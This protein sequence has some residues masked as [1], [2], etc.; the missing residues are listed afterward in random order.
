MKFKKIFRIISLAIIIAG[1]PFLLT[2]WNENIF[3]F[4]KVNADIGT[5]C[6]GGGICVIGNVAIPRAYTI[7]AG[8]DCPPPSPGKEILPVQN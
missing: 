4:N 6:P 3:P 8:S 5:C 2:D 1:S 7:E